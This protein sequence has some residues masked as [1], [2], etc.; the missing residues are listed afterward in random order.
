MG[1]RP[2]ATTGV[3]TDEEIAKIQNMAWANARTAFEQETQPQR[4]REE[5]E[6]FK[7]AVRT[8]DSAKISEVIFQALTRAN[9]RA[10]VALREFLAEEIDAGR[11]EKLNNQLKFYLV[12][13][14][15]HPL[16]RPLQSWVRET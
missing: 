16:V 15:V 4:E 1:R 6:H 14:L 5:F 3:I 9:I 10:D 2:K 7:R 8:G 11:T 12:Q 13:Y